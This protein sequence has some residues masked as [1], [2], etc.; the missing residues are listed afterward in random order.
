[1]KAL[2]HGLSS[3]VACKK[4]DLKVTAEY[5]FIRRYAPVTFKFGAEQV[6]VLRLV[7]RFCTFYIFREIT[8]EELQLNHLEDV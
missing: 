5:I 2:A 8:S 6:H 4:L 3:N 7:H 1:M